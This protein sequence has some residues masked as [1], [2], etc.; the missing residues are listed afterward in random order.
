M[1]GS[2]QANPVMLPAVAEQH[3]VDLLGGL[4][5]VDDHRASESACTAR[6]Q[7]TVQRV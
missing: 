4:C 6:T 3:H 1:Q 5:K 7:V 2:V